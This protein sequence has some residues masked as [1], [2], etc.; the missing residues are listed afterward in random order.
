MIGRS[1]REGVASTIHGDCKK[2]LYTDKK[3]TDGITTITIT[4]P[5]HPDKG[6]AFEY[7]GQKND[8]VR[9]MDANG[10]VRLL[11]VNCTD[12]HIAAVGEHSAEGGFVV[13]VDDLMALKELIDDLQTAQ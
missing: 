11:P 10:K 9:Y 3:S 1:D 5:F 6:R 8:Q 4:H 12:M 7:L 2:P 13:S